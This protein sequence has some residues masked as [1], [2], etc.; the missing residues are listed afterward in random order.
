MELYRVRH[1]KS[2][3]L[4]YVTVGDSEMLRAVRE[5]GGGGED[6]VVDDVL[7]IEGGRP[8]GKA[9]EVG[10]VEYVRLMCGAGHARTNRSVYVRGGIFL[11]LDERLRCGLSEGVVVAP[12]KWNAYYALSGSATER[13]SEPRVV[14]VDDCEVEMAK[15]VEWVEGEGLVE[16]ERKLTFNL[17]DGMGLISRE[18]AVEWAV[19]LGLSY[20]P[21]AYVVRNAFC[22][23]LVAT[24]DFRR[25]G[26]EFSKSGEIVDIYG[27]VHRCEDVDVILTKSQF[28][29]WG[30]YS[31]WDE[32]VENTHRCGLHWGVSKVA[33]NPQLEKK[34]VF[35]NYQFLQV[36]DFK[37]RDLEKFCD[38][39]VEWLKDVCGGDV[40]KLLLYLMGKAARSERLSDVWQRIGDPYVKA[41]LLNHDLARDSYIRDRITRSVEK[42]V[43]LAKM[44][45]LATDGNFQFMIADPY[46]LAQHAFGLKVTGLLKEHE[47]YSQYWNKIG[48]K[49]VIAERAPLTWRSEVNVLNLQRTEEMDDW[50]HYI[51]S[52]IIYNVWGV[53]CM[54]AA[55][56]DYDGDIV[57]TTNNKYMLKS[58]Y[59]GVPITYEASKIQKVPLNYKDLYKYDAFA[60]NSKIGYITN[61]STTLYEMLRLYEEG[62]PEYDEIMKRLKLCRKAQ[63]MEIDKAK[64]GAKVP[65]IPQHWLRR[66][67]DEFND[68]LV[69]D[70]R[71]YFMRYLYSQYNRDYKNHVA[72]FD[73]YC[74]IMY[75]KKY[76]ELDLSKPEYKELKEYYDRKNP[77][78]ETDGVMN[79]LCRY[80]EGQLTNLKKYTYKLSNEDAYAILTNNE[81]VIDRRKLEQMVALCEEYDKFK[82]EKMLQESEFN[83]YEQFYR[84][85]RIKAVDTISSDKYELAVLA[86]YVGYK[87]PKEHKAFCWDVFGGYVVSN[88]MRN[89]TDEIVELPILD[90]NGP[91]EYLG[92]RYSIKQYNFNCPVGDDKVDDALSIDEDEDYFDEDLLFGELE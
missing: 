25:F 30:A 22:K 72:D 47:H 14:V 90:E 40:N 3:E 44:G 73:R 63:G 12:S 79:R 15:V 6:G 67:G 34:S 66:N 81:F 37:Q 11:E 82:N 33:P 38:Y 89:K 41:M 55:D 65:S 76:H 10:G 58:V 26:E 75:G 23:G 2:G 57:Y 48:A 21:S 83:T 5:I 62:S 20:T 87:L 29:M 54:L 31:S 18:K 53:D 45:K 77:L 13:V 70:K 92:E 50:Y 59:G 86:A 9:V 91:I 1:L 85:L 17:W 28:K 49:Q 24:F 64:I 51:N 61:C 71:P 39:T 69:I 7:V 80:M 4:G 60:Y 84:A 36:L 88:L 42:K 43:R 52:G 68:K 8:D 46:G 19:D 32:Y 16:Q 78:L 56:S 35:T 27:K 74:V